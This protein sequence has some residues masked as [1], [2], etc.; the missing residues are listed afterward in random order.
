MPTAK[1]LPSGSWRCQVFSHTEAVKQPDG[2]LKSKRIYKSFTCDD[3]TAKGKRKAEQMAADWAAQK[4]SYKPSAMTVG[5][6]IDK[7]IKARSSILSPGTIREYKRTRRKDMQGIMNIKLEKLTQE[8]VQ[9]EIN[10]EALTH[11]PKTVRNMHGLLSSTLQV[12]RPAF[13]LNTTLPKKVRTKLTLPSEDDIKRLME[14]VE[15]TEL[16]IPVL[17]AAFGPM[18]RGEIAALDSDHVRGNIVHVEYALALDENR[19]W[20]KKAPKSISGNRY[21]EYPDFV[22]EKLQGIKGKITPL[23]PNQITDRFCKLLKRSDLPH[24][25]FH[26]LRHYSASIQHALG[27]PDSYIMARGG[28][29]D[30]RVLKE[31]YRHALEEKEKEMNRIANDHFEKL[32]NTKHNTK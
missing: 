5:E 23:Y 18:R 8:Q 3:T 26:D 10:Q 20:I 28:W 2:T 13:R 11:A 27:I 25:R 7:Y 4:E 24:F 31:I 15:G 29:G 32:C 19:K 30:D 14:L 16:E 6:A 12:Y 17:L 9:T 21:I 1:K 22:A